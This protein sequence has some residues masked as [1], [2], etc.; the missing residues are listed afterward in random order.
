M[1]SAG[2]TISVADQ[3]EEVGIREAVQAARQYMNRAFEGRLEDVQLEETELSDDE[4]K[5]LI[6]LSYLRTE[7]PRDSILAAA[8]GTLFPEKIRVYKTIT[9]D[10]RTGLARSMKIRKV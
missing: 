1:A 9:V 4:T 10:A 3:G 6:T 5:W 7:P 2:K 8:A